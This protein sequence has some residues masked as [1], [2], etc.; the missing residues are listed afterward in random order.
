[1]DILIVFIEKSLC[2]HKMFYIYI[3]FPTVRTPFFRDCD[4]WTAER[5]QKESRKVVTLVYFCSFLILLCNLLT[6]L[7]IQFAG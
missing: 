6:D 5:K 7:L 3:L 1:M 2:G 4:G